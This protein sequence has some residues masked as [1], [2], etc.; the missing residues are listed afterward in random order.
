M[1]ASER[2]HHFTCY[3]KSQKHRFQ[4]K[5][6]VHVPKNNLVACLDIIYPSLIT[7][8]VWQAFDSLMVP[9]Y[10]R[11]CIHLTPFNE[12]FKLLCPSQYKVFYHYYLD[13][14]HWGRV[15]HICVS[16]LNIISSNNGLSPG[17]HQAIIWT[18]AG[19]LLIWPL[20]TKLCNDNQNSYIF[21]LENTFEN[22]I[23]KIAA[24]FVTAS[25]C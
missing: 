15:M 11:L 24:I 16:K 4:W 12:D 17:R 9:S 8:R 20:G 19:I 18:N 23:W 13:L 2:N 25:M 7:V 3:H 1:K 21:L 14:T 10:C 22:V 6:A 5:I